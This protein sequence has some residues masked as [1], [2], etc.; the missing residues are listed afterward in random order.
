ME[1]RGP[2]AVLFT[3]THPKGTIQIFRIISLYRSYVWSAFTSQLYIAEPQVGS[4]RV[5]K[6]EFKLGLGYWQWNEWSVFVIQLWYLGIN[7]SNVS[8]CIYG[9][10][11]PLKNDQVQSWVCKMPISVFLWVS[12]GVETTVSFCFLLL[13]F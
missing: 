2:D 4:Y 10:Y 5:P 9:S 8:L 3:I 11:R 6:L 7:L 1:E 13:D 12:M